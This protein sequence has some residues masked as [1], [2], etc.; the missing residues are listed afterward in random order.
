MLIRNDSHSRPALAGRQN[1]TGDSVNRFNGFAPTTKP[2]KRL[3]QT[4]RWV[5]TQL[6]LG[7]NETLLRSK[8]TGRLISI[9]IIVCCLLPLSLVYAQ[10]NDQDYSKFLHTSSRHASIGCNECHRRT[11]NSSRPSFPGHKACTSC[12]LTQFTTP[13][14]PMCLI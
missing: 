13:T 9:L 3:G 11:D 5:V 4:T 10:G 2:L 7:V 12:H 8:R 6:K 1:I 14:L